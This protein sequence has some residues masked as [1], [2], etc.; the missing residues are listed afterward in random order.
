VKVEHTM[1]YLRLLKA[2]KLQPEAGAHVNPD[3][4]TSDQYLCGSD[5]VLESFCSFLEVSVCAC[6]TYK[7]MDLP[8]Y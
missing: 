6:S 2:V 5:D 8:A 1:L 4:I 7:P 3:F